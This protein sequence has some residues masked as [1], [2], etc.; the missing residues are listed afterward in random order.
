MKKAAL[1]AR[2]SS[3]AQQK[4][5]TIDSQIAELKKQIAKAGDE[6][7]KEYIDDGE[8]GAYLDRPE[9]NRLRDDLKTNAFDAVYFLNTDRIARDVAYQNIV[10]SEFIRYK[11]QLIINGKNYEHNPENKFT[12]T[13]LGAVAA[14]ERER[15]IERSTRG[16]KYWLQQGVL[17]SNGCDTFGYTYHRRT[18]QASPSYTVNK[19]EAA[20]VQKIFE[21]YAQGD[22]G[23]LGIAKQLEKDRAYRRPGTGPWNQ[24]H[25]YHI[26][27]NEMYTGVR[28]FDT[29]TMNRE[30]D[31]PMHKSKV[32]RM[33][34]RDRK[35]WIGIK[36]PSIIS[37]DLFVEVQ[38]RIEHNRVC[39]RNAKHPQLLSGLLFC[40]KC[41]SRCYS[42]RHYYQI[43]RV[44][45]IRI[46][47]KFLYTCNGKHHEKQCDTIQIDTR[48]LD[49]CIFDM[50]ENAAIDPMKL[51]ASMPDLQ[52]DGTARKQRIEKHV[53]EI[54][55]KVKDAESKKSRIIDL[56]AAGDLEREA[57]LK[58][59]AGYDAEI[60]GF[61][62][63]RNELTKRAPTIHKPEVIEAAIKTHCEAA[64]ARFELLDDFE[65]K[66]RFLMN[67][68][69]RVNYQNDH[70]SVYGTVAIGKSSINF[71]LKLKIDRVAM[72][73]QML[74]HDRALGL[75]GSHITRST[76]GHLKNEKAEIL[77]PLSS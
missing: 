49:A 45:G 37:K 50:I 2:V 29:M 39:Y 30:D 66:R 15:M 24:S 33:I 25:V 41:G 19:K 4:E 31:D 63:K 69:S 32:Q 47:E 61:I 23:A 1:Y 55:Q 54:D 76:F 3:D 18:D 43:K 34:T 27:H 9:M 6:L 20:V 7:V 77:T 68:I 22:V 72:R 8:S 44:R 48:P 26:L 16:R 40:G 17:M 64:K 13:V 28:Y 38:R 51:R 65:S 10:I 46:Y 35:E 67:F 59:I 42:Y 71:V 70:V 74:R 73:E 57:Y 56:Y 58:R 5:K 53:K 14:F 36:I 11:K 75:R 52:R 62:V 12:I 21:R 60:A